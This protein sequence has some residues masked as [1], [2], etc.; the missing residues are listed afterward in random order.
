MKKL[1]QDQ[2]VEKLNS[3]NKIWKQDGD[4]IAAAFQFK[5]FIEA[6][7]FMTQVA[8]EAEKMDHHPDWQN[9]YNKVVIKLSTHDA[10]GL[11]DLDFKL[12][13]KIDEIRSKSA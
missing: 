12:A 11:T 3:I 9:V 6:F 7:S 4:A 2:I 13:K 5:N 1:D 10:G 8:F